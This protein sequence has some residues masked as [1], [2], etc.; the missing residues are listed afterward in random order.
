MTRH[1]IGKI[2]IFNFPIVFLYFPNGRMD[3]PIAEERKRKKSRVKPP[4]S[5]CWMVD[6]Q[7]RQSKAPITRKDKQCSA[8]GPPLIAE[9]GP[10]R[11][12]PLSCC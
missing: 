4:A 6:Q 3:N 11:T 8:C 7:E 5:S 9:N 10:T 12:V 1:H 2:G